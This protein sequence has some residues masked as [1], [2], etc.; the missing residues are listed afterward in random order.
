MATSLR[1][2]N[3]TEIMNIEQ[4]IEQWLNLCPCKDLIIKNEKFDQPK[5]F[6]FNRIKSISLYYKLDDQI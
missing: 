6:T 2:K 5:L 1:S 4:A 3:G